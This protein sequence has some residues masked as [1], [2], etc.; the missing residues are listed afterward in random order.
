MLPSGRW[1]IHDVSTD[2]PSYYHRLSGKQCVCCFCAKPTW[3]F[4]LTTENV[5]TGCGSIWHELRPKGLCGVSAHKRYII[6]LQVVFLESAAEVLLTLS[7][8]PHYSFSCNAAWKVKRSDNQPTMVQHLPLP[9]AL[10]H[11]IYVRWTNPLMSHVCFRR[12]ESK[13]KCGATAIAILAVSSAGLSQTQ[14]KTEKS[15]I[16]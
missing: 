14:T 7:S 1:V 10:L 8:P 2:E 13:L 9:H 12:P 11:C 5:S 6:Q 15:N 4:S 3:A 16:I